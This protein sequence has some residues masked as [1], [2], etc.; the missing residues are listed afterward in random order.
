M[1][2]NDVANVKGNDYRIHFQ[3]MSK[4]YAIS[5]MRNSNKIDKKGVS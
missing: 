3:Y 5:I 4:D 1:S 2:L